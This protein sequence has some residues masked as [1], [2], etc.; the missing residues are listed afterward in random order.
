MPLLT[1]SHGLLVGCQCPNID[2]NIYRPLEPH[3]RPKHLRRASKRLRTSTG[4]LWLPANE[5][6]A[7]WI[8]DAIVNV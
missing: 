6:Y 4:V 1:P 7:I 2:Q 8:L 5:A 3:L